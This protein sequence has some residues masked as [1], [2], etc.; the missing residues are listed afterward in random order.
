MVRKKPPIG[1]IY[2]AMGTAKEAIA[3]SF[4]ENEVQY[5]AGFDI[6]DNNGNVN[7]IDLSIRLDTILIRTYFMP[8]Q[9]RLL[10]IMR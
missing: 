3:K 10:R 7:F 4:G 1:Y 6:I 8:T 2:E 5:K 9:S